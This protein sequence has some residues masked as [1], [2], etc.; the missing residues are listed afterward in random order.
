M[1]RLCALVVLLGLLASVPTSRAE[2]V[3]TKTDGAKLRGTVLLDSP[4]EVRIKTAGGVIAVP[5]GEVAKVER[6]K[7]VFKELEDRK[8]VLE[9]DPRTTAAQWLELA[10]WCQDREL[11][12]PSIDC[13][14][15]VV[16]RDGD[17]QD[18]RFELGYRRLDG[19]WVPEAVYFEAKG[20][21]RHEGSWVTREDKEKLDQGLVKVGDDWV[22]APEAEKRAKAIP[23]GKQPAAAK[24]ERKGPPAPLRGPRMRSP[25]DEKPLTPEEHKAAVDEAKKAGGWSV[26]HSS[27][28]YDF[29]SNGPVDEVKKLASTMDRMCEEYK[30]IFAYKPELTRSFPV[31]L[32]ANQ[33]EFMAKTG[34]GPGVGG[35]YDGERIVGFHG[36]LGSLTPQSVLFH[37]GTHQFQGLVFGQN[38]WRAKIWFIEGLAVFFESS[39]IDGKKLNQQIPQQ[40]LSNVKRAIQSGSYVH[41]ADLIRMEQREFGAI[42]YA[43]AWSLIYFLCNG[44]K[45]GL[46]RFKKYFEGVKEGK[47][48]VKL[49]EDL[50]SKPIDE[51]ETAWKAY[52]LGM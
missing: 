29:F 38:M 52:V 8:G 27:K 39:T 47:E 10:R 44:T 21:V 50:F 20:Y 48:G 6:A 9:R 49:F 23:Q 12:V 42:H 5:R 2:D 37:E 7:D 30:D 19:K 31:H 41:L 26:A 18:A 14:H 4:E 25:K 46:E 16:K 40:R 35:F 24:P 13:F 36:N 15:E 1:R 28:H 45:G 32:F 43:H 3:V 33:Q 51:I 11:W 22:P 17:N 34:H